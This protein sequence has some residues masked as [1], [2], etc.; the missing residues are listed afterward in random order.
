MSDFTQYLHPLKHITFPL[1]VFSKL[2]LS[3]NHL[4]HTLRHPQYQESFGTRRKMAFNVTIGGRSMNAL[5]F[6]TPTDGSNRN[7]QQYRT[8]VVCKVRGAPRG[9][10]KLV[11]GLPVIFWEAYIVRLEVKGKVVP[12]LN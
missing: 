8:A 9:L 6:F 4:H 1:N 12:V 5:V 11:K 7:L 3:L 10:K 2:S